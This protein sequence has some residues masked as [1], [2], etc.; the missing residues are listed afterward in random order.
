L[1]QPRHD[2]QQ[3][4]LA[5]AADPAHQDL[6]PAL[7]APLFNQKHLPPFPGW[8]VISMVERVQPQWEPVAQASTSNWLA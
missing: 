3:G 5:A 6:L 7:D 4:G 2:V 8:R 1:E